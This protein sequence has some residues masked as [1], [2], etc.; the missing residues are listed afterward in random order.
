MFEKAIEIDPDY[1]RAYLNL[2]LLHLDEWGLWGRA[3]DQNLG[4]AIVLGQKAAELDPALSGGTRAHCVGLS[5]PWGTR[6]GR[7]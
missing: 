1:A 6:Q 4:R 2:G 3:R 7:G 5:I